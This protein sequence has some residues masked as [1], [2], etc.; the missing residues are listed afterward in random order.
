MRFGVNLNIVQAAGGGQ[1]RGKVM[2]KVTNESS[3]GL[4]GLVDIMALQKS[5]E[6]NN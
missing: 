2:S 4:K 5:L 3:R 6:K 1:S